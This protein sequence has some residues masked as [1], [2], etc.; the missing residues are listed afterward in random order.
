[1][2]ICL[3]QLAVL[4]HELATSLGCLS[5]YCDHYS[6]DYP[7]LLP[8][9]TLEVPSSEEDIMDEGRE[10]REVDFKVPHSPPNIMYWLHAALAGEKVFCVYIHVFV[11]RHIHFCC[12]VLMTK[13]GFVFLGPS[14]SLSKCLHKDKANSEGMQYILCVCLLL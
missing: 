4:L 12:C 9:T 5:G 2:A 7:S 8:H 14:V 11:Y 6:T 13:K 10:G 3:P 1:M